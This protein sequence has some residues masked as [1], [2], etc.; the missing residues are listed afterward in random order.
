MVF[1]QQEISEFMMY[2]SLLGTTIL[3]DYSRIEEH[4]YIGY[5]EMFLPAQTLEFTIHM[6]DDKDLTES[7]C[8]TGLDDFG[9]FEIL[10]HK[11]HLGEAWMHSDYAHL[12]KI[13]CVRQL[14]RLGIQLM[15]PQFK[16]PSHSTLGL[17]Q[18]YKDY[19]AMLDYNLEIQAFFWNQLCVQKTTRPINSSLYSATADS[20]RHGGVSVHE[21]EVDLESLRFVTREQLIRLHQFT[22]GYTSNN[23]V[24]FE[25]QNRINRLATAEYNGN[26][27]HPEFELSIHLG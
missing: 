16:D 6:V 4:S 23:A 15:A 7:I 19:P 26:V 12:L 18:L 27:L 25:I 14:T 21:Y 9:C 3:A 22:M 8:M 17:G 5:G 13:A 11:N 10:I 2:H 20:L 1:T 24:M